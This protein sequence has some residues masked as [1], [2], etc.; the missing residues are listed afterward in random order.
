MRRALTLAMG[1]LALA[2]CAAPA[3]TLTPTPAGP[4][5]VSVILATRDLVPGAQRVA[6]LLESPTALVDTPAV[7]F[8]ARPLDGDG[9]PTIT[10]ESGFQTWPFGTRGSYAGVLELDAPGRWEL[11][12]EV[13]DARFVPTAN[14]VFT[15]T[16]ASPVPQVGQVPPFTPTKTLADAE[17][18][19]RTITSDPRARPA[20]YRMSVD[21]ALFSGRPTVVVF[22]SPAYCTAPTCG[23]QVDALAELALAHEGEANLVHVEVYDNPAEIAGDL[24]LARHAQAAVDWGLTALPG[25]RNESWAF[26]IGRDGR[27]SARFEGYATLAELEAALAGAL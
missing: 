11:T 19:L 24:T 13:D 2:A 7:L 20:L 21:E 4:V 8:S 15:V 23:P 26:V 17:G 27:I 14:A 18:D 10:V 1:A 25:Y 12:V 16:E 22:A 6:F 5:P 9:T 3:P